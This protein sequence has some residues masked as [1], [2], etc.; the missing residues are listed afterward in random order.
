[1]KE[2][3]RETE[4]SRSKCL[5]SV[6]AASFLSSGLDFYSELLETTDV[7]EEIKATL[8]APDFGGASVTIPFKLDVI[9]LLGKLSPAAEAIGAVK[10]QVLVEAFPDAPVKLIEMFDVWPA[11]E[12]APTVIVSTVSASATTT[13]STNP[14]VVLLPLALF[15]ATVNGVV[16]DM[17]YKPAE[18]PLLTFAKG[19][20]LNWARVMEVEVLLEQGCA[21]FE[22]WMGRRC[23]K[24]VVS[25]SV[26]ET[27][28]AAA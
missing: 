27:Y 15:D 17:A 14:G 2:W 7:G 12:P 22:T 8:A 24:L 10:S 3:P 25:K 9:P 13:D 18:T 23:P 5:G 19:A 4:L 26:L 20:A 28:F 11:E 21:Q 6:S 16:V 1:M